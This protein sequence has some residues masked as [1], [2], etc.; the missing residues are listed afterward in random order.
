MT[1]AEWR[2]WYSAQRRANALWV[3]MLARNDTCDE[4]PSFVESLPGFN[5]FDACRLHGDR[6]RL[7]SGRNAYT[8][9]F[10][11]FDLSRRVRLPA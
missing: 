9:R 7:I 1:R 2:Q 10:R 6:L 11:M 3:F 8:H 4:L 5:R